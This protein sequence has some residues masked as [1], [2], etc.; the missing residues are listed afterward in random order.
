MPVYSLLGGILT[1]WVI[2]F[3]HVSSSNH[4]LIRTINLLM[5]AGHTVVPQGKALTSLASPSSAVWSALFIV[6]TA[7]LL[8]ITLSMTT[9]ILF[10]SLFTHPKTRILANAALWFAITGVLFFMGEALWTQL[11]TSTIPLVIFYIVEK[12]YNGHVRPPDTTKNKRTRIT[13]SELFHINTHGLPPTTNHESF[14]MAM[15]I[16]S[17]QIKRRKSRK[18]LYKNYRFLFAGISFLLVSGLFYVQCDKGIFLRA[19]DTLLLETRIGKAVNEF[20]YTYTLYAAQAIQSPLQQQIKT[21]WVD[22]EFSN[23]RS[24][25]RALARYGWLDIPDKR[26]TSFRIT[27]GGTIST[28]ALIKHPLATLRHISQRNDAHAVMRQFCFWGLILALPSWIFLSTFF[29]IH[30][31]ITWGMEILGT[32]VPFLSRRFPSSQY[33]MTIVS[34]TMASMVIIMISLGLIGKL[35]P[36]NSSSIL[37]PMTRHDPKITDA[38]LSYLLHHNSSALRVEALRAIDKKNSLFFKD[39]SKESPYIQKFMEMGKLDG[40][41]DQWKKNEIESDEPH[42]NRTFYDGHVRP[43]DTTKKESP[44]APNHKDFHINAHGLPPTTNNES[45]DMSLAINSFQI[46]IT[47]AEKYW[48]ANIM[49]KGDTNVIPILKSLASDPS[50]NVQCSAVR[51]LASIAQRLSMPRSK[52]SSHPLTD[53]DGRG[54][55]AT[56]SDKIIYQ[57]IQFL[58]KKLE[59]PH[60][61]YVQRVIYQSIKRISMLHY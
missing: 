50:I 25:K 57:L 13:D 41:N 5:S 12:Q 27:K 54:L 29:S 20:Y 8:V 35:Y 19:R 55:S 3:F 16:N 53:P 2:S 23:R 45:L 36:M 37:H 51:A 43:P 58:H 34:L 18:P 21:C 15:L 30:Y 26:R 22:P 42:V 1:A 40:S 4:Q 39:F 31:L 46:K 24:I 59:R 60:P 48:L 14:D 11:Y 6:M 33:N 61:W 49:G 9:A 32:C 56:K 28:D 10:I 44:G 52:R 47:T 38:Q 17:F 7:G